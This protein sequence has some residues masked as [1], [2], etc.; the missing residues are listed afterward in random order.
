[1]ARK[2]EPEIVRLLMEVEG[3]DVNAVDWEGKTALALAARKGRH[4]IVRVLLQTKGMD[5]RGA[6]DEALGHGQSDVIKALIQVAR[7][8]LDE[9]SPCNS[10]MRAA[11]SGESEAVMTVLNHG[12]FDINAKDDQGRSALAHSFCNPFS[13]FS[14]GAT[15]ALLQI[16]G[17][18]INSTDKY[19]ETIL[20]YAS[21]H[22]GGDVQ[23]LVETIIK[24]GGPSDICINAK[25]VY[26]RT[27][28][29]HALLSCARAEVVRTLLAAEG[30]DYNCADAKGQTPLILATKTADA[31]IVAELLGFE[32]IKID[33]R[34]DTGRTAL[35]YAIS[36]RH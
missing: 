22:L 19:G 32:G 12:T 6:L 3:V 21:R 25:D 27:A 29:A 15:G 4:D 30:F 20:M 10:L 1:A 28:L 7:V 31:D 14:T 2:G 35:A 13:S 34:D 9:E 23:K 24:L 11:Q 16:P 17:I 8:S 26:G 36:R 18:D 5:L 33:S